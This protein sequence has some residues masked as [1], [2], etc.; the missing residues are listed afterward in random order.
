MRTI[1]DRIIVTAMVACGAAIFGVAICT[2]CTAHSLADYIIGIVSLI[3]ASSIWFV[4]YHGW[5]AAGGNRRSQVFVRGVGS[6]LDI[7]GNN[8]ER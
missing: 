6:I 2:L 7:F 5:R 1:Y 4:A 3:P 8:H